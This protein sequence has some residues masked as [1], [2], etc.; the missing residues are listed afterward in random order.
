M[1]SSRRKMR[2]AA[3]QIAY[4]KQ[5][6]YYSYCGESY[7]LKELD[8]AS[9]KSV[10]FLMKTLYKDKNKI[11]SLI[12]NCLIN[13]KQHRLTDSLNI[14]LQ[15]AI[16]ESICKPKLTKNIIINEYLEITREFAG[17]EAVKICNGILS[18]CIKNDKL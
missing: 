6:I 3:F 14:I 12:K 13:W 15:L 2:I 8:E 11:N 5:K 1:K 16:A 18:N 17:D 4:Q 7:I 9:E 10:L